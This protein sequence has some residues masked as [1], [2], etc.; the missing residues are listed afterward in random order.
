MMPPVPTPSELTAAFPAFAGVAT[1][2]IQ[3]WIDRAE[4]VVDASWTA[5]DFAF[6]TML[7]AAHEMV[8][9]GLGSGAEAEAAAGGA[10]AFRTLKSGALSI[11]R[12]EGGAAGGYAATQYGRQFLPLLARN[13]GGP[14]VTGGAGDAG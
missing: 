6:A 10:S 9:N 14:R 3:F 8:L 2:Q 7:H 12:F 11:E 5:D 1:G 4:R 13:R